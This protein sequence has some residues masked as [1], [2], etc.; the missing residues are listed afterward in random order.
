MFSQK[1]LC[2][3]N[4]DF[5]VSDYVQEEVIGINEN[6]S[7]IISRNQRKKKRGKVKMG[8]LYGLD[9]VMIYV[10]QGFSPFSQTLIK[11]SN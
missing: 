7:A 8:R 6:S 1:F 4:S 5:G 2:L 11:N 3:T 9:H 10:V